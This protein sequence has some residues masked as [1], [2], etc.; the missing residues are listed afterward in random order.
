M[1]DILK[2]LFNP[3]KKAVGSFG[4]LGNLGGDQGASFGHLGEDFGWDN[5][6]KPEDHFDLQGHYDA[7]TYYDPSK[8]VKRY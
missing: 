8:L 5:A 7:T 3:A 6:Y 4:N 2:S 1:S